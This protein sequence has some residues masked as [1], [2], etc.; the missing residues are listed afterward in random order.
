MTKTEKKR[1]KGEFDTDKHVK[2]CQ[3]DIAQCK[4][5]DGSLHKHMGIINYGHL[6]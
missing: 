4:R 6:D 3:T 5:I 1:M 2:V